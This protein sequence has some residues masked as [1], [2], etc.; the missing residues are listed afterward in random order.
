MKKII[1]LS[2]LTISLMASQNNDYIGLSGGVSKLSTVQTTTTSSSLQN[3]SSDG[4]AMTLTFGHKY[5][6]GRFNASYTFVNHDTTVVKQVSAFNFAY[7]F[8]F[9]IATSGVALFAGPVIGYSWYE[10][11]SVNLDGLHY[12]VEMGT[13]YNITENFSVELGYKYFNETA[14]E[15]STTTKVEYDDLQTLYFGINYYFSY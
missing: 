12:G 11:A 7:D 9:P 14:S 1:T 8:T 3:D 5:E 4:V 10:D 13:F 6:S 15:E 2:L